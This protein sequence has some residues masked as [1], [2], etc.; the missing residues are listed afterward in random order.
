MSTTIRRTEEGALLVPENYQSLGQLIRPYTLAFTLSIISFGV[1]C[2]V[3]PLS[4]VDFIGNAKK[5]EVIAGA[6]FTTGGILSGVCGAAALGW[7]HHRVSKLVLHPNIK[8]KILAGEV[9]TGGIA[10]V[11]MGLGIFNA[12][13]VGDF[14]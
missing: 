6:I 9:I 4:D 5:T 1:E 13:Y 7:A 12:I 8:N 3:A 11:G 14:S 2:I 10:A